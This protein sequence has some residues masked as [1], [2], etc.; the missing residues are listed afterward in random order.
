[1]LQAMFEYQSMICRLTGMDVSNA[2]HY[3]GATALAEAVLLAL[4]ATKRPDGK[5]ILPATVHPQYRAVVKTYLKGTNAVRHRRRRTDRRCGDLTRLLDDQTA[6]LVIQ[7]PNFFGMFERIEGL[8]DKVHDAGALLIVVVDPISLGLFKPPGD[9]GADVVVADGQPLGLPMAFGGPHL[10]IFATRSHAYPHGL[11]A[12][13]SARPSMRRQA[14]LC[15]DP[16]RPGATHSPRQGD[17]QHMHQ[18]RPDRAWGSSLPRDNG[19]VRPQTGGPAVLRQEPL[20][21]RRDCETARLHS[22]SAGAGHSRSSKSSWSLCRC[23]WKQ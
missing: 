12:G 22:Q 17:Q 7:Q 20:C 10:G 1:M 13:W 3:D 18:R 19:Q 5:V 14:R 23:R 21:G 11:S 6:A 8:A 2:S 4:D 9:Y 16:W 15:P